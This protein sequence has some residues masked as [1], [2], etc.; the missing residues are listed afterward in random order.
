MDYI[1]F[2]IIAAVLFY[3]VLDYL[4]TLYGIKKFGVTSEGN[5]IVRKINKYTGSI[6][7]ILA[8]LLIIGVSIPVF[9]YAPDIIQ[10]G[11]YSFMTAFGIVLTLNNLNVIR[12]YYNDQ[13]SQESVS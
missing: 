6:G 10:I 13:R 3:G 1:T 12:L 7:L 11:F 8:K 5:P 2:L 9:Y 4:T